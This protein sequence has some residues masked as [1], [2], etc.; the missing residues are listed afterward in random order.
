MVLRQ[1]SLQRLPSLPRLLYG[2][3]GGAHMH[4]NDISRANSPFVS[5]STRI[6]TSAPNGRPEASG[7]PRNGPVAPEPKNRIRKREI[8]REIDLFWRGSKTS[9]FGLPFPPV[10]QHLWIAK[11]ATNK[12]TNEQTSK[13]KNNKQTNKQTNKLQINK[14]TTN[15]PTNQPTNKQ[16]NQCV[17]VLFCVRWRVVW[18]LGGRFDFSHIVL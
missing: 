4:N 15:Q 8:Q 12:H 10:W 7:G 16:T 3:R 17:R 5:D 2:G 6:C 18:A 13:H 1:L 9:V 14:Q 11:T